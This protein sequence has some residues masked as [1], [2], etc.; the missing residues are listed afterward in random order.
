VA[1]YPP[2]G[3]SP[4]SSSL[5]KIVAGII[6]F[7]VQNNFSIVPAIK[8]IIP[9]QKKLFHKKIFH[10]FKSIT[11]FIRPLFDETELADWQF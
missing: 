1:K 5:P 10:L 7:F 11:A 6:S 8:K 2:R 3:H 9:Q 4:Q